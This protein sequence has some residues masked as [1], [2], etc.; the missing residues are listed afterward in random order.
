MGQK[1]D[2]NYFVTY[3]RGDKKIADKLLDELDIHLILSKRYNFSK[4]IDDDILPDNEE[5]HP[6]IVDAL[7]GSDFA[8]V[9]ATPRYFTR[10]YIKKHEMPPLLREEG[11]KLAILVGVEPVDFSNHDLQGFEK[12]QLHRLNGKFY[13]QCNKQEKKEFVS[14]LFVA[15]EQILDSRGEA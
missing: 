15:I 6:K 12:F 7:D 2:K 1:I 5:Y 13:S 8:L 11:R 10:D 9:L 3:A 4:W 14:S